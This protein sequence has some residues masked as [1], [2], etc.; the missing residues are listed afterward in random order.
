MSFTDEE[1]AFLIHD[2]KSNSETHHEYVIKNSNMNQ[3]YQKLFHWHI[4]PL[5]LTILHIMV[6]IVIASTLVIMPATGVKTQAAGLYLRAVACWVVPAILNV[7]VLAIFLPVDAFQG[8]TAQ[9]Y[10]TRVEGRIRLGQFFSILLTLFGLFLG[11]TWSHV[12]SCE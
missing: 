2:E 5:H 11:S 10:L 3:V 9:A 7:A 4:T 1:K 12:E 8:E 6:V